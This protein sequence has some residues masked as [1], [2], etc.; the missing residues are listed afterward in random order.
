MI[1]RGAAALVALSWGIA[2]QA[3]DWDP[4]A[5][6]TGEFETRLQAAAFGEPGADRALQDWLAAHPDLPADRRLQASEQLCGDY[7]VLTWH[8]L[9]AAVCAEAARLEKAAG[10]GEKGDDDAAMA[11]AFADQP[12]LRAIGS[13]KVPLTW[14][15]FGSQSADVTVG[16]VTAS[17]FMDTGAEISVVREGLAKQMHVRPVGQS[18]RVGTTTADVFGHVGLIDRLRIGSA[19]VENVPVLVLP[20]AQLKIGNVHQIDGI[21]GLQVFA[22]FGRIAWIDGGSALALGEA[23]PKAR[24]T[25][26]RIY[27]HEEGLGV[28]V[29][30]PRGLLGAFLD[31]GANATDW[32]EPGLALLDPR[33]VASAKEV[34]MHVGGAGGVVEVK[35]RELNSVGLEFG[36]V[37]IRLNEVAI[38]A[39]DKPGAAK[40]GMDAVSQLGVLI[41]DFEQMRI[42]GRLKTEAERKATRKTVLTNDDVELDPANGKDPAQGK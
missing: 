32:R 17:W 10:K 6:P 23:A 12:P 8:R 14:N 13:A 1:A 25:A 18:I 20:D 27:W 30:T 22:A 9:R 3:A 5:R 29:R 34:V 42:D 7:G 15:S 21:L 37:P 11:A 39:T 40:V 26:P 35:Q 24:P 28:P 19:T 38:A 4:Y 16:G 31:T 41:L 2:A 36:P 33:R